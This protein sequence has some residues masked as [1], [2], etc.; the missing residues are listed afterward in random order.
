[1]FVGILGMHPYVGFFPES[2]FHLAPESRLPRWFT[3]ATEYKREDLDVEIYYY[4]PPFG[5]T[6]LIAYLIGPPPERKKLQK[7]YG[8]ERWHPG[9]EKRW[10]AKYDHYPNFNLA[11]VD[12]VTE[13]IEHRHM[14][15]IFHVS[16]DPELKRDIK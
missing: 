10:Y 7:K 12:G 8:V 1:M 14:A 15:P 11:T 3:E 13:L 9:S 16:D 5:K 2:Q 4:T 6:N